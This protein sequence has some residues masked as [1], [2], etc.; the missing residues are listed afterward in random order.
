[1]GIDHAAMERIAGGCHLNRKP[2]D[3]MRSAGFRTD[4]LETGYMKGPLVMSFV[5]AGGACPI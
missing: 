3:L 2:D 4:D 5:Y 1:M